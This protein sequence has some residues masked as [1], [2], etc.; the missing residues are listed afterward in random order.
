MGGAGTPP[1]ESKKSVRS[2]YGHS[3]SENLIDDRKSDFRMVV[4]VSVTFGVMMIDVL[5]HYAFMMMAPLVIAIPVVVPIMF[6]PMSITIPTLIPIPVT[7][8]PAMLVVISMWMAFALMPSVVMSVVCLVA[9][10]MFFT[11]IVVSFAA[12]ATIC[13]CVAAQCQD[14]SNQNDACHYEFP[15]HANLLYVGLRTSFLWSVQ[16]I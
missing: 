8:S 15:C 1:G 14:K 10:V 5:F 7:I 13:P 12:S 9:V 3:Y 4:V 16:P 11:I 6:I 2:A